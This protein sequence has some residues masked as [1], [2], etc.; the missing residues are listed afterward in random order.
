MTDVNT[1]DLVK[2]ELKLRDFKWS[3]YESVYQCWENIELQEDFY[4][5]LESAHPMK[6]IELDL[7]KIPLLFEIQAAD[8]RNKLSVK[9]A[10]HYTGGATIILNRYICKGVGFIVGSKQSAKNAVSALERITEKRLDYR[11]FKPKIKEDPQA[12]AVA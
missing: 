11:I 1:L 7:V 12:T 10:Y 2:L 9:T 6:L 5:S 4:D 3:S 8:E